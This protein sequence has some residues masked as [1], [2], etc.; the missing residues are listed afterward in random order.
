MSSN[1][2]IARCEIC[3]KPKSPYVC[4]PNGRS[5]Y[6]CGDCHTIMVLAEYNPKRLHLAAQYVIEFHS[7]KPEPSAT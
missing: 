4:R 3:G 1:F 7:S 5:T 2:K 6:L